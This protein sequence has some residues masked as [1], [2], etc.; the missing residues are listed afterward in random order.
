MNDDIHRPGFRRTAR[1]LLALFIVGLAVFLGVGLRTIRRAQRLRN[2]ICNLELGKST[3]ADVGRLF[4]QYEGYISSHDNT[5]PSCSPEGCSY[6]MFVENPIPKAVHIGP[7]IAFFAKVRIS[8]NVLRE[9]YL[10]IGQLKRTQ[11]FEIFVQQSLDSK[12]QE[13]TRIVSES[14]MPRKGVQVSP[15]DSAQ[16]VRLAN[17]LNQGCLVFLGWCSQPKDMLPYLG[18][19]RTK[20][21]APSPAGT[22]VWLTEFM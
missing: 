13:D 17:R 4:P 21:A 16:F 3:F 12:F 9:R 8:N 14:M 11:S 7:Q 6:V 18:D 1:L 19:A 20:N 10:C 2:D 22:V 5:P 15:D